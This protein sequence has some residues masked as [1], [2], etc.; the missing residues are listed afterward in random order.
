MMETSSVR[1]FVS[2]RVQTFCIIHW[3]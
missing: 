3:S 1:I 2:R